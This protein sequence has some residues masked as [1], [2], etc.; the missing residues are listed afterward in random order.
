VRC[1]VVVEK[2][3]FVDDVAV[4]AP[5]PAELRRRCPVAVNLLR[6]GL[7]QRAVLEEVE[8]AVAVAVGAAHIVRPRRPPAVGFRGAPRAAAVRGDVVHHRDDA[9]L[10]DGARVAVD[11]VARTIDMGVGEVRPLRPGP[12]VERVLPAEDP[13]PRERRP[14]RSDR[15]RLALGGAARVVPAGVVGNREVCGDKVGRAHRQR[16]PGGVPRQPRARPAAGLASAISRR[17]TKDQHDVGGGAE[18]ED[19]ER[20]LV[21]GPASTSIVQRSVALAGTRASPAATVR[22][23]APGDWPTR[24][25]CAGCTPSA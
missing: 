14:V 8:A 19:R 13:A 2:G 25:K 10:E 16:G 7:E 23:S 21:R 15:H 5:R 18:P 24:T 20:S 17:T 3:I 12:G 4:C 22:A 1:D 9:P 6:P 11:R